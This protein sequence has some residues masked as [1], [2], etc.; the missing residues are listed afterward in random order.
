MC[1]I[2]H[3]WCVE[4]SASLIE[5]KLPDDLITVIF[6]A[7]FLFPIIALFP[8]NALSFHFKKFLNQQSLKL[9]SQPHIQERVSD[10]S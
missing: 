3:I 6:A 1:C 7:I 4:P 5:R 8:F 10:Y 9:H 2:E